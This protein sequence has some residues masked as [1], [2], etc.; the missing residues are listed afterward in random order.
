MHGHAVNYSVISGE[1]ST[2]S[3]IVYRYKTQNLIE[4]LSFFLV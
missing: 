2:H 1:I 4:L 3:K